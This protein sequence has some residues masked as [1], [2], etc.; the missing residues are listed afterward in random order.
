M[1]SF[2]PLN[3]R[4]VPGHPGPNLSSNKASEFYLGTCAVRD[5]AHL[6]VVFISVS[7]HTSQAFLHKLFMNSQFLT[8][9]HLILGCVCV[10][11]LMQLKALP[12]SPRNRSYNLRQVAPFCSMWFS[13]ATRIVVLATKPRASQRSPGFLSS[14]YRCIFLPRG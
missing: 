5:M 9:C 4:P 13:A 12:S 10:C 3:S 8:T 2:H 11:S 7:S 14:K 1:E 6:S